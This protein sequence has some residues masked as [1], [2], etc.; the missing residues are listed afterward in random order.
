MCHPSVS[1]SIIPF[2]HFPEK[3]QENAAEE[4]G[5]QQARR[6][7]GASPLSMAAG[8]AGQ[9]AES[10]AWPGRAGCSGLTGSTWL[11]ALRGA[12]ARL[13]H[14]TVPSSRTLKAYCIAHCPP[15]NNTQ[16]ETLPG[17]AAAWPCSQR[18]PLSRAVQIS[19]A[20]SSQHPPTAKC[21]QALSPSLLSPC[22]L[23]SEPPALLRCA[24]ELLLGRAV[25]LHHGPLARSS[26][27]PRSPA[28]LSTRRPDQ[29][30]AIPPR[31]A[32]GR[33]PRTSGTERQL[34]TSLQKSKSEASFLQCPPEGQH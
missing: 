30:I 12:S 20:G 24:E 23:R 22:Q 1:C 8:A 15:R 29:G 18:L 9:L 27:C 2:R 4:E 13:P 25:S 14:L 10:P 11:R 17:R 5:P 21:L 3:K 32:L 6:S 16:Q 31:G 26:L 34:K 33:S 7:L 19:P 28:Q